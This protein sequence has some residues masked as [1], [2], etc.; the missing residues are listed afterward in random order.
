M[1]TESY[2]RGV[3]W[4]NKNG[5]RIYDISGSSSTAPVI[6]TN[7]TVNIIVTYIDLS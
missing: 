2:L 7:A 5:I 6:V 1:S 4:F 3:F